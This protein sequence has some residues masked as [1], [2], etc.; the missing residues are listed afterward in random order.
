MKLVLILLAGIVILA[1]LLGYVGFQEQGYVKAAGSVVV[2]AEANSTDGNIIAYGSGFMVSSNYIVTAA[3]VVNDT[4]LEDVD[5]L[6]IVPGVGD[7]RATVVYLGD[8]EGSSRPDLAVLSVPGLELKPL[9]LA[10]NVV[11]GQECYAIGYP[12]QQYVEYGSLY[13][14]EPKITKGIVSDE[15]EDTIVTDAEIDKGNSGGPIVDSSGAVIGVVSYALTSQ[16]ALANHNVAVH[17]E[18]LK[19]VLE[20][21]GVKYASP[22]PAAMLDEATLIV[23]LAFT[24][25]ALGAILVA[26]KR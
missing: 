24:A 20:A 22:S 18:Q 4:V 19:R 13:S 26:S 2:V 9:K 3:H 11:E 14:M 21:I 12:W 16:E 8:P 10:S 23:L 15:R 7:Y 25:G 5:V 6:V 1:F 17:V